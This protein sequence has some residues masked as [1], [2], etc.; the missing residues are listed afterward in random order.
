MKR[1]RTQDY[2][3][4]P[5][6]KKS[7]AVTPIPVT[8]SAPLKAGGELKV[9]DIDVASYAI[10]TT[11]S[12]TLLAVPV[13]GTDMTNRVGRRIIL[14]SVYVRGFMVVDGNLTQPPPAQ[15]STSQQWR[16]MLVQDNQPNGAA[17]ALTAILKEQHPASQLNMDNRDRFRVLKDKT[18][19]IDPFLYSSTA[20]A[21]LSG[22]A[23][24]TKQV[25]CY[26]KLNIDC[27]FNGTNGGTIADINSG[28][29]WMVWVGNAA[30]VTGG[31]DG[32]FRG[33]TRVRFED[34]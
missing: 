22:Q 33:T 3:R 19:V 26:K 4:Q 21:T 9:F 18:W 24:V 30:A 25:K 7:R 16:F 6:S 1:K 13:L 10:N 17:P 12:V 31:T 5:Q 29:L 27:I 11:G 20:T 23:N 14:K 34:A 2:K 8:L 28:A 15:V 32:V